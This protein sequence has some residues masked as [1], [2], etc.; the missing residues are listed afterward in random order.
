MSKRLSS[1]RLSAVANGDSKAPCY[2]SGL[3]DAEKKAKQAVVFDQAISEIAKVHWKD[4][5]FDA[6]PVIPVPVKSKF[7]QSNSDHD[8]VSQFLK[9]P[10]KQVRD[11]T[12]KMLL[13]EYQFLLGHVRRHHNEVI[14]LKCVNTERE[15]ELE[16]V[17]EARTTSANLE[18]DTGSEDE[19]ENEE[20]KGQDID[21]CIMCGLTESDDEE[22]DVCIGYI[23]HVSF[24]TTHMQK[25]MKFSCA[26]NVLSKSQD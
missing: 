3:S 26:Q 18:M 11:D 4:A 13:E 8:I 21:T 5:S 14:I 12:H 2:I 15:D 16:I 25:L 10:L 22:A 6:F 19:L 9:A 7:N 23:N 17:E 24:Y 1:V 20:C